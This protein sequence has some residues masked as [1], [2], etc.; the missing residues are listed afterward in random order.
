M[1]NAELGV[2]VVGYGYWSPKLIRNITRIEG[3]ALVSICEKDESRHELIKAEHPGIAVLKHYEDALRDPAVAAVVI[4][5]V[6]SSH[7][8][9]AKAALE[10]GK[11]VLVEKPLTLTVEEGSILL[12]QAERSGRTLMVDHT[13]LY[14]PAIHE[15]Q[16]LVRD[17]ELGT[18]YSIEC[19]RTNLG[20][21]QKDTNVIWD[22]APHDFSIIL[23]LSAERP[24]HVSAVGSKTV[25]HPKQKGGGQESNAHVTLRY[26]SGLEAHVHVSWVSPVKTRQMTLVGSER[27]ARYDQMAEEQVTVYDQGVYPADSTS[28]SGPLFSYKLGDSTH[29][30]LQANGEDLERML[31]DFLRSVRTGTEPVSSG[32]L[33]LDVVRLL[34]A[35]DQSLKRDGRPVRIRYGSGNPISRLNAKLRPR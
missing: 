21:F 12:E 23:S 31:G 25:V 33:A 5:T 34:A 20:L 6:P 10:A 1:A 30:V 35:A 13:Y 32:R 28:E 18:L 19:V 11:H 29:P 26:P 8:R 24:S 3:Y 27:M 15:L 16:R 22:L 9:I 2:A 7:Y 17:G 4:A 14:T